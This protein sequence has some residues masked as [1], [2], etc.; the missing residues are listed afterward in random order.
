MRTERGRGSPESREPTVALTDWPSTTT[1]EISSTTG[2]CS[3]SMSGSSIMPTDT[4]KMA[5][6]RSFTGFTKCS[7]RSACTV[8]ASSAPMMNAPK[9]ALKPALAAITTMI[10]HRA[11]AVISKVSSFISLRDRRSSVG[12]RKMP[13]ANQ[14]IR[15]K[16]NLPSSHSM[17]CPLKCWLTATVLSSTINSTAT[18]SSITNTPTTMVAK[19]CVF[20]PSSS[21][22][23]AMMVVELMLMMPPKNRLSM[24]LQPRAWPTNQPAKHMK[25]TVVSAV[26]PAVPPTLIT[27]LK[28]N[29][30]P[31]AEQQEHHPNSDHTEMLRSSIT[32]GVNGM[33][34][35]T[36]SPAMM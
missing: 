24:V 29:S 6:K 17:A 32:V 28:L 33:C 15:K 4:K 1:A 9:A 13:T 31:Q 16:P 35:P 19:T 36:N 2:Q 27:F 20:S 5:P 34:G 10:R 14:R 3:E 8:P 30:K 11:M 25:A 26:M 22:A 18:T 23:R 7:I 12:M 21:K